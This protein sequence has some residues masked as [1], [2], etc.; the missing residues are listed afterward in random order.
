MLRE[1]AAFLMRSNNCKNRGV[2]LLNDDKENILSFFME[3]VVFP[4]NDWD[5]D[6]DD[7]DADAADNTDA[8]VADDAD[9]AD[10]DDADA[11][12]DDDDGDDDDDVKREELSIGT[13][14]LAP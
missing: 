1:D 11:A 10:D 13:G 7:D 9:T 6:D 3:L 2:F 12:D 14:A 8:A 5:D 4:F